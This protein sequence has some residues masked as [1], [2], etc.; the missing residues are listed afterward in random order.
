MPD[1]DT[2]PPADAPDPVGDDSTN[3]D[4][5]TDPPAD[6][7]PPEGDDP[8]VKKANSEAAKYRTQLRDLET[9]TTAQLDGIAKALGLKADEALDPAVLGKQLDGTKTELA[10]SRVELAVYRTAGKAGGDPDALLDSRAFL[11]AVGRLDPTDDGFAV[12]LEA[13]VADAVKA[14]PKLAGAAT[15]PARSGGQI[16]GA[17]APTDDDSIESYVKKFNTRS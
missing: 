11:T 12:A 10:Q 9:R 8:R 7:T 14:N 16:A 5:A 15:P 13:A 4:P 1:T 6:A 3:P 2:A 17:P